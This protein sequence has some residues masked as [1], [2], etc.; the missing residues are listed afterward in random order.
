MSA[1]RKEVLADGV[2]MWL[3][4]CRDVLPRLGRVDAVVTDPPYHDQYAHLY[5]EIAHL[6]SPL[7]PAGGNFIALCGHSQVSRIIADCSAHLRYWWL[8]GMHHQSLVRFPGKWVTVRFKP[9][10]WFVKERRIMNSKNQCPIDL[11]SGGERDKE[12]HEWGQPVGWF[13]HWIECT[14][15]EG[16][17]ILDPFMGSGTTGVACVNLGRSFIGV[18]IEPKYFDIAR[19]RISETLSMPRLPLN[20]PIRPV[21]ANLLFEATA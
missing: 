16:D 5:G 21:Q 10:V 3:G 15:N 2:E 1:P 7:L 18:E 6:S 12:H 20:E 11:L 8:C 19:R 13:A 4:D 9:A 17:T 14:T